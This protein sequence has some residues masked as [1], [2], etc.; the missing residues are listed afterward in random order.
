[1]P[2]LAQVLGYLMSAGLAFLAATYWSA[3]SAKTEADKMIALA[4]KVLT[5]KVA[6]QEATLRSLQAAV[7]P[8]EEAYKQAM[9]R[10]LTHVHTPELD[11]LMARIDDL[12]EGEQERMEVLLRERAEELKDDIPPHESLAARLLVGVVRFAKAAAELRAAPDVESPAVMA[13][14]SIPTTPNGGVTH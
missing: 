12:D 11:D 10:L 9:I 1:M 3:R 2:P 5:E 6:E 14:V 8:I 7:V 13:V 4:T